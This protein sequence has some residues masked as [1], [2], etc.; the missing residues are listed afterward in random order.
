MALVA[1]L[2]AAFS[3]PNATV[4]VGDSSV[5]LKE[6]L[7][8]L[9]DGS[10]FRDA[11]VLNMLSGD[12]FGWYLE[13]EAWDETEPGLRQLMTALSQVDFNIGMKSNDSVRDLFKGMYERFMPPAMRH[14]LG[15]Y[16][17]P[18]WLAAHTLDK[19]GWEPDMDLLDPTCGTG[20]FLLEA[21]K[22]RLQK[23]H[24]NNSDKA[25]PNELVQGIY[26]M[27][28]NPLAV[29]AARSS[30]VVFLSPHLSSSSPLTVPVWLADAVNSAQPVGSCFEHE[31]LTEQ[32]TVRFRVPVSVVLRS[33]FGEIL[34]NVRR[35]IESGTDASTIC[36]HLKSTF[37]LSDLAEDDSEYLD[38]TVRSLVSL[39]E[40]D[41]DGIW[42]AILTERFK[43]GAI[44]RV[45]AI[46]GN[47]PW[48]KWSNLPPEYAALIRDR[49]RA[50]GVFSD[51]VWTG[52]IES[53]ISTV[54]TFEALAKWL[55]PD[56]KLAFLMTGTVF[57][58]ESSSG[59]RKLRY[60]DGN[61]AAFVVVEDF[62]K[63]KPFEGVS[64]HPVLMILQNSAATV[65]PIP[66]RMWGFRHGEQRRRR[67]FDTP[68]EFMAAAE[69]SD[70]MAVPVYGTA[71]GPW[72]KGTREQHGLWRRIFG[73][74]ESSSYAARKGVCT[75]RNG[76]FFL[77]VKADLGGGICRVQNNPEVGRYQGL[78][79]VRYADV[80]SQHVFP[81]L[82]GR[83]VSAFQA[84]PDPEY[85]L[86]VPQRGMHGDSD[87]IQTAPKVVAYL[88]R[89]RKHLVN[90]GS[91]KR[92][93]KGRPFWSL[94]NVGEYTFSPYKV[95]WREMAGQNFCAAY[96][97]E[98]T[99]PVLGTKLVVPDHKLY[100]VPVDNEM[101][102][103]YLT[104]LLNAPSVTQAI[105]SYS[106]SLSLGTNV[107]EH[108]DIP[109]YDPYDLDHFMLAVRSRNITRR[110]GGIAEC[111][112]DPLDNLA[113]R[114]LMRNR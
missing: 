42:C 113:R 18:D 66:Y 73:R 1:K 38:D 82:R 41:W 53:D 15:E 62:D 69:T 85:R 21:M 8:F 12:F 101:E 23:I 110:G 4:D 50:N 22:R 91:Y 79:R 57:A 6:R 49:C 84:V 97:S 11:G 47:P 44:P 86:L 7:Q 59:F 88:S 27:D 46:A 80:E 72:L 25:D 39:H 90:R 3:L 76:V 55:L 48:V 56:G 111:E 105:T 89:F 51:A 60:R 20:T 114:V 17:T 29:L 102:A 54:I 13:D 33:D 87:L 9:E 71:D 68:A 108:L 43:A 112:I 14:A 2:V 31:L 5:D 75:D 63:I 32:G 106:P 67:T 92:Y 30:L 107:V 77:E 35:G 100:F 78:T 83:G 24:S 34:D 103:A 104:G 58:N 81:L 26:G 98:S 37:G 19:L 61:S 99:D 95:V 96:V 65:Y 93:Q 64:N 52:G 94:W 28:L 45:S 70:L 74:R 10:L 16:Y 40:Q 109:K 36:A